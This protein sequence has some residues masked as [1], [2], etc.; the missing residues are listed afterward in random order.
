[1]INRHFIDDLGWRFVKVRICNA[2]VSIGAIC[3]VIHPAVKVIDRKS[4]ELSMEYSPKH[5]RGV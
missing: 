4:N 5:N 3:R 2:Y 1:M